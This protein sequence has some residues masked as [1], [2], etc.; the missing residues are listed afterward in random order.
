MPDVS[1][2]DI[3]GGDPKDWSQ[4]ELIST[5]GLKIFECLSKLDPPYQCRGIRYGLPECVMAAYILKSGDYH[6]NLQTKYE[7][8]GERDTLRWTMVMVARV[9]AKNRPVWVDS[10]DNQFSTTPDLDP[11][12][13]HHKQENFDYYIIA[14]LNDQMHLQPLAQQ[15]ITYQC[16]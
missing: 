16:C 11:L 14:R 3:Y 4:N 6:V 7:M 15:T 1:V 10:N 2:G 13:L 12:I 8:A 9:K 5:F